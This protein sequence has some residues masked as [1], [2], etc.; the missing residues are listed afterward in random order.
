ME[1]FKR[2]E[3][4]TGIVERMNEEAVKRADIP[5]IRLHDYVHY[6]DV[7]DFLT[8]YVRRLRLSDEEKAALLEFCYRDTLD[9]KARIGERDLYAFTFRYFKAMVYRTG[10]LDTPDDCGE[11]LD[12]DRFGPYRAAREK[13]RR[14]E[15]LTPAEEETLR[16]TEEKILASMKL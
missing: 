7:K 2:Y 5:Y 13:Q 9:M 12:M 16:Y 1:L 8:A 11:K 10:N 3:E 6:R 14:G 4:L 15:T